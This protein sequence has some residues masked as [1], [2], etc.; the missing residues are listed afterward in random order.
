MFIVRERGI[1][2]A[3]HLPPIYHR[4]ALFLNQTKV[5]DVLSGIVLIIRVC[6]F[7]SNINRITTGDYI[8]SNE[9]ILRAPVRT[10]VGITETFLVKGSLSL[11]L[12]HV[13]SQYSTRKNW[14]HLFERATSIIFCVPLSDYNVSEG[15]KVCTCRGFALMC[16]TT[17][18]QNL[19]TEALVLF[20]SIINSRWFL[21]TSVILFLTRID[22]FKA[23]LPMVYSGNPPRYP[24]F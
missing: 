12:S 19:M 15:G 7:S 20:E 2:S 16:M 23:K 11:R 5:H 24:G 4:V 18:L 9:D 1:V 10:D 17:K 3:S 6:S 8:P 22:E 21:R 13:S 14:L